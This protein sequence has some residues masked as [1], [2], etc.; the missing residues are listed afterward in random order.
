VR[1]LS[2]G[3]S[4]REWGSEISLAGFDPFESCSVTPDNLQERNRWAG[5]IDGEGAP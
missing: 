3:D 4:Q 2:C 1:P 5:S